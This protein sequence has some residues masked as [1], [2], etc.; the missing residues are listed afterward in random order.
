MPA[1]STA[2]MCTNTSF[3]PS[4]GVMKPKPFCELKNLTV[5]V[6]NVASFSCSSR[7]P[8]MS[9]GV[10]S[11]F[12]GVAFVAPKKRELSK[13]DQQSQVAA[14]DIGAFSPSGKEALKPLLNEAPSPAARP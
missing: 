7:A 6:A 2:L 14:R 3:E 8:T 13:A 10:T 9:G 4:D 12:W 5:P 1:R 11:E